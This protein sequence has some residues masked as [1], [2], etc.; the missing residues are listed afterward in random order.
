[1]RLLIGIFCLAASLAAV[2]AEWESIPHLYQREDAGL[3][4]YSAERYDEAF[5]SLSFTAARGLKKSQYILAFMF[6]KGQHVEKSTLLAMGWLG[7][8]K[9]SGEQEWVDLYDAIYAKLTPAQ[10][11]VVDSRV[12]QYIGWYGM[13]AQNVQCAKRHATVGSR[14][15]ESTCLKVEGKA[16][17]V[18]PV[19]LTP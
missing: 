18:Y 4:H 15:R 3:R 11:T 10:R 16:Y 7:V 1:M 14:R 17:E 13:A 9:E 5:E 6:M 2:S 12:E 19:Q 8:A